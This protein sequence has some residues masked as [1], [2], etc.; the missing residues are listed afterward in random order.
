MKIKF[1]TIAMMMVLV[2][3]ACSGTQAQ[4]GSMPDQDPLVATDVPGSETEVDQPVENQAEVQTQETV[5]LSTQMRLILGSMALDQANLNMSAEQANALL[6]LW[7]V[8]KNLLGSDTSA[9]AEIEA[10]FTQIQSELTEE[11]FNW[12]ENYNLSQEEYQAILTEYVPEELLNSGNLMTEEEREAR[13]ATA[14]AENGGTVPQEL[15]G[16]GGGR[17]MGGGTGIPR[18]M[19][20]ET[21]GDG[22]GGGQGAGA[23]QINIYLIDALIL[24]LESIA[25]P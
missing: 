25:T 2:L 4:E 13:R 22:T 8:M 1:L 23:G 18:S 7:K 20:G 21:P 3:S 12:V 9:A 5:Q 19:T 15:Q 24:E 11:Q 10:L 14:I 17:G 6:P 16:S